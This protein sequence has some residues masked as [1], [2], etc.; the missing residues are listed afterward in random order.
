MES[1]DDKDQAGFKLF[2]KRKFES[3]NSDEGIRYV[4][5]YHK[6][7]IGTMKTMDI[8]EALNDAAD[9]GS[10]N[11]VQHIEFIKKLISGE[12]LK[13]VSKHDRREIFR[14]AIQRIIG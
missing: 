7:L 2:V 8:V 14:K 4:E 9:K 5:N 1:A 3:N 13:L 10:I 12:L 6:R 11:E